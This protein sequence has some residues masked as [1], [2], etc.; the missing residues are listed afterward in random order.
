LWP[1]SAVTDAKS[2][3]KKKRKKEERY[4]STSTKVTLVRS[5]VQGTHLVGLDELSRDVD[6]KD[7]GFPMKERKKEN[8]NI[9]NLNSEM[10]TLRTS[11]RTTIATAGPI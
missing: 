11:T 8:E 1:P 5:T 10:E 2:S 6:P 7:L 4:Y 9:T 3:K